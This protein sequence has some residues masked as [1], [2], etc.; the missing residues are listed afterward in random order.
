VVSRNINSLFNGHT[1]NLYS[2]W[3]S[4]KGAIA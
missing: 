1:Q 3:K 4:V 2:V